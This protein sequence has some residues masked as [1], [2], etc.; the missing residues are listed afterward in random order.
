[1]RLKFEGDRTG[2]GIDLMEVRSGRG[3]LCI[4]I[5]V[6]FWKMASGE[7]GVAGGRRA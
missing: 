4:T 2:P 6:N 5:L 7:V 1:M 3:S